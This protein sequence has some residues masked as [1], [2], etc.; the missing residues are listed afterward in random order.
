MKEIKISKK[1]KDTLESCR[2]M[3]QVCDKRNYNT[4]QTIERLL[5]IARSEGLW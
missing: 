4:S 5:D 3:F 2:L 1:V